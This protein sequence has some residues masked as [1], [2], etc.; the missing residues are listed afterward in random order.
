MILSIHSSIPTF[1]PIHFHEGF[2]VLL[3]DR[4]PNATDKQTRNSAGKTST[5]EIIH[6]LLGADCKPDSLFRT[7]ALEEHWFK[8]VFVIDGESFNVERSGKTPSKIFILEGG[9]NREEL[10]LKTD[11]TTGRLY[12]SNVNWRVFL[13][14]TMFGMPADLEGSSFEESY[15]PAFR[16]MISYFVR[17]KNSGAFAHPEKQAE[18]QQRWDWQ[19][20]LSYLFGLDWQIPFEFQKVRLR[21]K[22]LDEL[23]KAVKGGV[24]GAVV[25]TVAELRP[26]VTVAET[27]AKRLRDQLDNFEVL[28]SYKDLSIRAARAKS[29]MQSLAHEAISFQET[30]SHLE[31]ALSAESPPDQFDL[32]QMYSAAGVE[33]PGIALRRFEE[34]SK[35]YSSVVENR[36]T[37]LQREI[38]EAKQKISHI[39]EKVVF[40]DIERKEILKTLEGRGALDDFL[41][42]QKELAELEVSAATLRERFKSAELLEGEVTQL[43]IDRANLKR[44]LQEDHQQRELIL[45]EAILIVAEAITELYQDRTGGFV[46]EATDNGP[47][48]RI[49][50][51]GDRGGGISNMEIFCLDLALLKVTK[52]RQIGPNF[53][54]HD[55]H[56]FDG[57]D[58][59]QIARAFNLGYQTTE[60]NGLQYIV[61]MNSD[62]FDKLSLPEWIDRERVV[63]KTRLSDE[64][65]TGGLFGFR[66]D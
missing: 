15:T 61:T 40:L 18:Q 51:Q 4:N 58:E 9:Q 37:H 34:V 2:N 5:I 53:L 43:S 20:N 22:T 6:F 23:K 57:V 54:I 64:T 52:S 16:S 44:R 8:G 38:A 26:Q 47:E 45:D 62:I 27:K 29:E 7:D 31:Q 32:K 42:L 1:K 3:A 60:A 21:E 24:L 19:V 14:H 10:I 17:R 39:E 30:L 25:G 65:E 33:L 49:S 36:K 12:T 46:V 66:F 48:F 55:S 11:R 63:L 50:I 35:F 28:D 56:L 59:R 13:G 41:R